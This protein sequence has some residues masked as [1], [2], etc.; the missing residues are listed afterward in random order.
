MPL[1]PDSKTG[2]RRQIVQLENLVKTRAIIASD[3]SDWA[4]QTI[5]QLERDLSNVRFKL[6]TVKQRNQQ[7]LRMVRELTGMVK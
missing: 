2:L 1:K 4:S 5:D 3:A 6:E 7:L